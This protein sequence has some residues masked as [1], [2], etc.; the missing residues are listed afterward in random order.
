MSAPQKFRARYEYSFRLDDRGKI[1]AKSSESTKKEIQE[2]VNASLGLM[3][4]GCGQCAH[5]QRLY[6]EKQGRPV[7]AQDPRCDFFARRPGATIQY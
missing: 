5:F 4:G 3:T 6:C 1:F 2:F 7:E